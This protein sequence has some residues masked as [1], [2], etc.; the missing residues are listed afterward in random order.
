MLDADGNKLNFGQYIGAFDDCCH[1]TMD[2]WSIVSARCW[3]VQNG[4]VKHDHDSITSSIQHMRETLETFKE[5]LNELEQSY[6]DHHEG[7]F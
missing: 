2:D 5:V 1:Q 6:E 3:D 7:K 4:L